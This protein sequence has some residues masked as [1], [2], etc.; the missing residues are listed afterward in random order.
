MSNKAQRQKFIIDYI[1]M[2]PEGVDI[3]NQLFVDSY[4]L[5]FQN[6]KYKLCNWGSHKCPDLGKQLA[7]LYKEGTLKRGRMSLGFNWQ[8]GLP[9]WVYTYSLI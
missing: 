4:L 2:H 9:K 7:L 6:V 8:P 3:L 5:A 1:K